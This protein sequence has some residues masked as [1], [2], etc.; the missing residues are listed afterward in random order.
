MTGERHAAADNVY[1]DIVANYS[2]REC[3]VNGEPA[4]TMN[5]TGS[6]TPATNLVLFASFTISN[7]SM[8]S[9]V[10][11]QIFGFTIS[12]WSV[13]VALWHISFR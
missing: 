11:T 12:S 7:G 2:T 6:Y 10:I 9:W 8:T 4:A 13:R 5:S 1:Y 3:T